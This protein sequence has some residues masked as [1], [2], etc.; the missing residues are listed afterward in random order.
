MVPINLTG[1][2]TPD[3]LEIFEVDEYAQYPH[4]IRMLTPGETLYQTIRNFF[5]YLH[6]FYGFP[7]YFWSAVSLLPVKLFSSVWPENTRLI[8]CVLREMLSVLPMILSAGILTW[9]T[10]K[11]KS[12]WLSASLFVL[13]LTMPAV[14]DNYFWWHPDSLTLLFISLTFLFLDRDRMRCGR[15]FLLAAAACGAAVGTKYLGFY[16]VLSIPAYLLCCRIRKT[17]STRDLFIKAAMFVF[18]MALFILVSDPLLLLPQER[19]EIIEIIKRQSIMSGEGIFLQYHNVFWE[20]GQFPSWVTQNYLRMFWLVLST[21]ALVTG[22]MAKDHHRQTM[23]IIF[24]LY[25]ITAFVINLNTAASR[26]HYLLPIILPLAAQL[27]NLMVFFENRNTKT[28]SALLC[29]LLAVQIGINVKTCIPMIRSQLHREETSGAVEMYRTLWENILPLSE[30]PEERMTR[31]FRDWKV[32]YPE[33]DGYAVKTDWELGSFA[34]LD[35]WH[36]DLVLLEQENVRTYSTEDIL[37]QAVN[38]DR[39]KG[40]VDFYS[41]AAAKE[42]P[43]YEFLYE[44]NFGMVFKKVQP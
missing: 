43:G 11:F 31:I 28:A 4:V 17:I 21:A 9:I 10:T 33:Q 36:P 22:V 14:M 40:T 27:P 8:I 30:V 37:D 7:F 3:T 23:S 39:M 19:A 38:T 42:I 41:A 1:A 15:N 6:Y 29:L 18:V 25:L 13:T 2:E 16:F 26:L 24:L 12:T 5:I 32:Y 34:L 44:D 35:E 20:N